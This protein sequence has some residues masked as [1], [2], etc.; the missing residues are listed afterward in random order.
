MHPPQRVDHVDV[1]A[2]ALGILDEGDHTAFQAHFAKCARC[3]AEYREFADLP[4]LLDQLKPAPDKRGKPARSPAL[5]SK[6]VLA[7]ALEQVSSTRSAH[8]RTVWL[9]AA[10]AAVLLVAVPT[11]VVTVANKGQSGQVAAPTVTVS[12]P[13]ESTPYQPPET[14]TDVVAA[15]RTVSGTNQETG[16]G[17]TIGIEPETWGTKIN[18]ELR[19][20]VGPMNCQ[21]IAV[22]K[23]GEL[24]TVISWK[25]PAAGFGVPASPEPL[26]IQGGLS[27]S[28]EDIA[29]FSLRRLD[30]TPMLDVQA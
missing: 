25:V 4:M 24:Y 26:R 8:R 15:A 12:V 7:G 11:V 29:M 17:A 30:G 13:A 2:Y 22:T 6:R 28:S 18:L 10:A 9:G 19:G 14:G 27:V 1:A 5:P 23:S 3:R 21:L 20:I 16:V